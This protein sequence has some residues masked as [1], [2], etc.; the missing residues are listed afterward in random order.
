MLQELLLFIFVALPTPW[1]YSFGDTWIQADHLDLSCKRFEIDY[2][3]YE[4]YE[5]NYSPAPT[6]AQQF[7][8]IFWSAYEMPHL[9]DIAQ[10]PSNDVIL[11]VQSERY[12]ELAY[13]KGQRA[14][15]PH[16]EQ[17][18]AERERQLQWALTGLSWM[19]N[20]HTT[21]IGR[22]NRRSWLHSLRSHVG[23]DLYY[24]GNLWSSISTATPPER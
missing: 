12:E 20:I 22:Y 6:P 3:H 21:E 9:A 23:V 2:Y 5:E 17:E 24:S 7:Y 18:F 14:L 19:S 13:V 16:L 4:N 8:D 11:K 15:R 10:F 1:S